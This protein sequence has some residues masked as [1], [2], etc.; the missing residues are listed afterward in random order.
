MITG[1]ADQSMGVFG[2]DLAADAYFY[3]SP[4]AYLDRISCPV[5]IQ[6]ATGDMLVPLEQMARTIERPIDRTLFPE[7]YTRD[8]DALTL[9]PKARHRFDEL[10]PSDQLSI[11]LMPLPEGMHEYTLENFLKE[12]KEPPAPPTLDRPWDKDKQWNIVVLDEGSP[13]PFSPHSRYKWRTSPDSF[14]ESHRSAV[15]SPAILNAA[16]LDRLMQRYTGEL[17]DLAILAKTGQQMNRLNYQPLEQLDV[18]QG[19]LDYG[20]LSPAHAERLTQLYAEGPRK[21]FGDTLA[22]T[23]LQDELTALRQSLGLQP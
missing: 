12:E 13:K 11:Q 7:N 4:I 14:V 18:V 3:I 17:T 8:F 19:L 23:R 22:V 16:K 20:T 10:V 15:P 5:L 2:N 9:G 1:L 21:P 6:C